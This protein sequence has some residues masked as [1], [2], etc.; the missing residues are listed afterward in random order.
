MVKKILTEE[1]KW[2][3]HNKANRKWRE[4]NRSK[5]AQDAMEKYEKNKEKINARRRE[6]YR[7]KKLS[8]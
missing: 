3:S 7:L 2:I 8:E 5:I 4:K 1:E 6:L